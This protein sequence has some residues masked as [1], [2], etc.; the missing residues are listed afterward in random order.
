MDLINWTIPTPFMYPVIQPVSATAISL[1]A[2]Q[3]SHLFPCF[4][5]LLYSYAFPFT[6]TD[7]NPPQ[8]SSPNSNANFSFKFS[9]IF[10]LNFHSSLF[11]S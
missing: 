4:C 10:R 3:V 2:P 8:S 11:I 5:S 6:A 9:L 1:T 7:Q